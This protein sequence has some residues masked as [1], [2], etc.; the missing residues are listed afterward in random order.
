MEGLFLM[1][2]ENTQL[3]L[4]TIMQQI[5]ANI[6]LNANI[7]TVNSNDWNLYLALITSAINQWEMEQN[8]LWNELWVMNPAPFTIE[9]NVTS[10]TL[11]TDFKF[12]GGGML[13][14]TM[15]GSVNGSQVETLP[16]KRLEER[17][18]NPRNNQ[19]EFYVAGNPVNGYTLYLG[20]TP[21]AGDP[22]IGASVG[23]YYY[24]HANLLTNGTDIPEMSD[25]WFIVY[26]ACAS[27]MGQDINNS[28]YQRMA[29]LAETSL[30]NMVTLNNK[31]TNFQ[32]DYIKDVDAL[33]GM[34]GNPA[35]SKFNSEYWSRS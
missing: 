26:T 5:N 35:L 16:V 20:W 22:E 19:K 15:T 10:F 18:L 11:P 1:A 29:S 28:N 23:Y 3:S 17:V 8:T 21:Q 2:T 12:M 34:Q 7:P 14:V 30:L 32:D 6:Y 33:T 27:I 25:G 31:S 13:P 4:S 9:E 24:K